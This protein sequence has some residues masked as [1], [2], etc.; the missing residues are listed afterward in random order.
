MPKSRNIQDCGAPL[1]VNT[2]ILKKIL[3]LFTRKIKHGFWYIH[4]VYSVQYV[5]SSLLNTPDKWQFFNV[6]D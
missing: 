6:E 3:A 2:H 1:S 5:L 4:C